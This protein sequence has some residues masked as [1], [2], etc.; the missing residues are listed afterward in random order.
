MKYIKMKLYIIGNGFDREHGLST[1]YWDFRSFLE[2]IDPSFL[3]LF[4]SHY[5]IY[6]NSSEAH[7]KNL[8]WNEFE[9]NLANI[10]EDQSEAQ[11]QAQRDLFAVEQHREHHPE[12]AL[13]AQQDGRGRRRRDGLAHILQQ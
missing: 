5:N 4:E 3:Y 9:T 12:D 8:L 11:R 7:K 1:Q 13:Q 6:P 2:D 10:D